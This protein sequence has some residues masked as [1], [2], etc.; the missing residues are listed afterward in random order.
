MIK[1]ILGHVGEGKTTH[2]LY[3][4]LTAAK[5]HGGS[6]IVFS[7]DTAESIFEKAHRLLG[8]K[9]Y[10]LLSGRIRVVTNMKYDLFLEELQKGKIQKVSESPY[11][12]VLFD[13]TT[14]G[15]TGYSIAYELDKLGYDVT[16]TGQL[17]RKAVEPEDEPVFAHYFKK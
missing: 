3:S 2:G 8:Q 11:N 13:N 12:I 14:A 16:I 4:V 17:M 9:E 10:N 6:V 15:Q 1:L 7:E 5:L